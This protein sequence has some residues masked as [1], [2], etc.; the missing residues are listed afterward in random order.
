MITPYQYP[1]LN[2]ANI[3]IKIGRQHQ[4]NPLTTAKSN[5]CQCNTTITY[6]HIDHQINNQIKYCTNHQHTTITHIWNIRAADA[7]SHKIKKK[8]NNTPDSQSECFA[9]VKATMA[10]CVARQC[11]HKRWDDWQSCCGR[12]ADIVKCN[13]DNVTPKGHYVVPRYFGKWKGHYG[14]SVNNISR[15]GCSMSSALISNC[16]N[17]RRIAK[18]LGVTNYVVAKKGPYMA[19]QKVRSYHNDCTLRKK[20]KFSGRSKARRHG[21]LVSK[22]FL[23]YVYI[24]LYI[25]IFLNKNINM[26]FACEFPRT[27]KKLYLYFC[28]TIPTYINKK[29]LNS[30]SHVCFL[31]VLK[32]FETIFCVFV[33]LYKDP[34][35]FEEEIGGGKKRGKMEE[36]KDKEIRKKVVEK[37]EENKEKKRRK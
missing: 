4:T 6:Y 37:K 29:S 30:T 10:T 19:V 8:K 9:Q 36:K 34:K 33:Q 26:I 1:P 28:C 2:D 35:V 20:K 24:C 25:Y 32:I 23:T 5:G 13:D 22:Y 17:Y 27:K 3:K 15:C 12:Q 14:G 31:L 16:V 11:K 18:W 7:P 21:Q